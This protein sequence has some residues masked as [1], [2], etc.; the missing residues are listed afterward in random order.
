M[1]CH[2]VHSCPFITGPRDWKSL[3]DLAFI[4]L[5]MQTLEGKVGLEGP[6]KL[7]PGFAQPCSYTGFCL[8]RALR[9]R[10]SHRP[11][12]QDTPFPS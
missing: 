5:G 12:A 7:D 1:L 3:K 8:C 9:R 6:R 4:P 2:G 11:L 10:Q